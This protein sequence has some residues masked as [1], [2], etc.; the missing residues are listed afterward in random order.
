MTDKQT[1]NKQHQQHPDREFKE[2]EDQRV[3]VGKHIIRYW[4]SVEPAPRKK[5]GTW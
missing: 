4:V 2:L 5:A 1:S 3:Q